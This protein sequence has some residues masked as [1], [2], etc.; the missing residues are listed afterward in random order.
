MDEAMASEQVTLISS[1]YVL[2]C[3]VCFVHEMG[4]SGALRIWGSMVR[5]GAC[6]VR[7]L[8]AAAH[9]VLVDR[10]GIVVRMPTDLAS[11][12]LANVMWAWRNAYSMWALC[13][14]WMGRLPSGSVV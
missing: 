10:G 12:H 8:M 5:S 1:L 3:C 4:R 9:A 14:A 2:V 11:M 6:V 7:L 13:D